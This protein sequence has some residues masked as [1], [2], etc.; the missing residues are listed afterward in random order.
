VTRLAFALFAFTCG[1]TITLSDEIDLTWDFGPSWSRFDAT[2]HSPYVT[3]T[4]LTLHV[5]SSDDKQDFSGWTIS[6]SDSTVLAIDAVSVD[7]SDVIAKAHTVAAGT[8][9]LVVHDAD[10]K[11]VGHGHTEVA[12]PD[13]IELDAHAYL[14]MAMD[15]QAPVDEVR[16]VQ[17]GTATYLVRYFNGDRE[18]HGFGVLGVNAPPAIT[19]TPRTT[20][21]SESR[22]WLQL[23]ATAG[24]DAALE[25][26]VDGVSRGTITAHVVPETDMANVVLI[27]QPEKG[28][29]DGD[30]LV[31]YA[32]A[33]DA[34]NN[35]LFGVD[36]TWSIDGV[37]QTGD[38][39]LYRYE[40]KQGDYQTVTATRGSLADSAQIQSDA[41]YVDSSNNLGCADA[42]GGGAGVGG[43]VVA[44]IVMRRRRSG[45]LSA[46]RDRRDARASR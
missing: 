18:L 21:L 11:E 25:M 5:T 33:Y 12:A 43:L 27:D 32:Q 20:F 23:T 38:G 30:W 3:G 37:Q 36:Y 15:D 8:A 1:P 13:R 17:G 28:H 42:G 34:A 24:G 4:P 14:I 2:L 6:S 10:G 35:R 9:D 29:K 16:I 7:S 44:A 45:S 39:D 40:Y 46:S 41:G 26:V 19:A 31:A 22:E